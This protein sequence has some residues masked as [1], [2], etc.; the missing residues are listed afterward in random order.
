MGPVSFVQAATIAAYGGA[1]GGVDPRQRHG[2]AVP[3]CLLG[4]GEVGVERG[5]EL[6]CPTRYSGAVVGLATAR[7][8]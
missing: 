3:R 5:D 1:D 8:M 6:E 4:R 2:I 7:C